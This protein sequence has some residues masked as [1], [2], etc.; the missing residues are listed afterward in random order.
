VNST[1][2]EKLFLQTTTG[3]IVLHFVYNVVNHAIILCTTGIF[4]VPEKNCTLVYILIS[5]VDSVM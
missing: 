4:I 5:N 3:H 1:L 2:R